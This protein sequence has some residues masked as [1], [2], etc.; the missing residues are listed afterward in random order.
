MAQYF[1]LAA[2]LAALLVSLPSVAAIR[3]FTCSDVSGNRTVYRTGENPLDSTMK[4]F[5]LWSLRKFVCVR[6]CAGPLKA[7]R[8][9][10]GSHCE[11]TV[12][13]DGSTSRSCSL[14]PVADGCRRGADGSRV[15][16][17][18]YSYCNGAGR[19]A[20][21]PPLLLLPLLAGV[22]L[23]ALTGRLRETADT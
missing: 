14:K 6:P 5:G 15:C 12:Y 17:C 16:A 21:A 13:A 18:S 9:L 19:D 20:P 11:K 4:I 3:C 1:L 7:Y 8:C 23:T 10:P 2:A 22:L